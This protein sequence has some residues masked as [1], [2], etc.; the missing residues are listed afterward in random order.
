MWQTDRIG[1]AIP[2]HIHVVETRGALGSY[3]DPKQDVSTVLQELTD[4]GYLKEQGNNSRSGPDPLFAVVRLGSCPGRLPRGHLNDHLSQALRPSTT[5]VS[6]R[7][8]LKLP[9]GW[10]PG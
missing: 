2:G 3:S 5:E 1:N 4:K 10:E 6:E 8:F 7:E 9:P